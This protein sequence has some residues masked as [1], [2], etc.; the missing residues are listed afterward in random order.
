MHSSSTISTLTSLPSPHSIPPPHPHPF[1]HSKLTS[2]L[3]SSHLTPHFLDLDHFSSTSPSLYPLPLPLSL[4]HATPH[5][6]TH[7]PPHTHL[8]FTYFLFF[9]SPPSPPIP[10]CPMQSPPP[11]PLPLSTTPSLVT[12]TFHLHSSTNH[13][14]LLA[15]ISYLFLCFHFHCRK[16]LLKQLIENWRVVSFVH[17]ETIPI[18]YC[19]ILYELENMFCMHLGVSCVCIVSKAVNKLS[20]SNKCCSPTLKLADVKNSNKS[21]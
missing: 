10:L 21:T 2:L 9:L 16:Y 20:S 19:L 17:A 15:F 8:L 3:H 5:L 12:T 13:W 7:L 14:I 6:V 11:L 1:S 18:M 4:S